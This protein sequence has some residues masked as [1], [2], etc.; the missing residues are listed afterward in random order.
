MNE[1]NA[2][3]WLIAPA[4]LTM[5]AILVYPLLFSMWVSLFNW[6]MAGATHAFIGD[7]VYSHM[8]AYLA[9]GFAQQWLANLERA[10]RVLPGNAHL[11][12]GHGEPSSDNALFEWQAGY[13]R[14]F[15][16][17]LQSA[18]DE[19]R[20]QGDALTNLVCAQMQ[21]YLPGDDLLFLLRLS[22]EPMRERLIA[23]R[24]SSGSS[25]GR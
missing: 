4:V 25:P 18:V 22:V 9:D 13:I 23:A 19:N 24:R 10:Q 3:Y 2:H 11:L 15:L 7:L 12:M 16:T 20:V 21:E 14:R 5:C 6:R 1:R 8:H 17:L